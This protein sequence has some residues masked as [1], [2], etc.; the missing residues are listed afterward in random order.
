MSKPPIG[1]RNILCLEKSRAVG[2]CNKEIHETTICMKNGV[3][4]IL[5]SG[6]PKINFLKIFSIHP[7]YLSISGKYKI[8]SIEGS[9]TV[10]CP[11]GNRILISSTSFS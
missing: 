4:M 7:N 2:L 11:L 10:H 5:S 1:G 8:S 6:H 9:L 3:F